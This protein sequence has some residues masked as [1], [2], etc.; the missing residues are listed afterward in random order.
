[1]YFHYIHHHAYFIYFGLFS[2]YIWWIET[3][4]DDVTDFCV[5]KWYTATVLTSRHNQKLQQIEKRKGVT[6]YRIWK[7]RFTILW[8]VLRFWIT[9]RS[10]F[11]SIDHIHT[12][13]FTAAIPAW[14]LSKSYKKPCTITIHE[15]YDILRYHLK[16]KKAALYIRF[17]RLIVRLPWAHIVTVSNY[18]KSMIQD[19]YHL[20][21][22]SLSV[23][24]NQIDSN[25]WNKDMV[26]HEDIQVLQ[27]KYNLTDKKIGLFIGRLGYE[28]W[29][30]YLIESLQ[31]VI[32]TH[33][34][35][36]LVIIAPKTPYLYP[37]HIQHQIKTTKD[38]ITNNNLHNSVLRIDP[39]EDNATLRLWMA[40]SNIGIIPSMS[41]WFCYT[42]VQ[43]QAMWLSLI[44][45]KVGA[46]TEV[47]EPNHTF[48]WYGKIE[49]L[50]NAIINT[51]NS[52]PFH[53]KEQKKQ[54]INYQQ[55]LN[56]FSQ[57]TTHT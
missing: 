19:I 26:S 33:H 37:K 21:D 38:H 10:L 56:L 57:N 51:I 1:M 16:W 6:I 4:F 41:E 7:N 13:T 5:K 11:Q 48:V 31:K 55:Y 24:Y 15:I 47:L 27:N 32:K 42:A 49:A 50:S 23:I 28:K 20:S 36:I 40:I 46:L 8:K 45:S 22:K 54:S 17:E 53:P 25:F 52:H 3:L 34:N 29:L 35:F 14:I 18:T 12:S 43:M 39:V 30:P 2:P 44:S 9:H